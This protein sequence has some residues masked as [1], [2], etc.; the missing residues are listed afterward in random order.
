[1]NAALEQIEQVLVD[2]LRPLEMKAAKLQEELAGVQ[3]QMARLTAAL[4]AL[5]GGKAQPR[6]AKPGK[7][8]ATK[9]DVEKAVFALL[10]QQTE[11][12]LKKLEG[13]VK[14]QLSDNLQKSLSGFGLR[15]REVLDD[16]RLEVNGNLCRLAQ[17]VRVTA[18]A[19]PK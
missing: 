16:P 19:T 14:R 13:E 4:R 5:R 8:Y 6:A 7:S 18:E 17:A 15:F 10:G 11:I 3:E 2:E 12:P 9:R 1:M